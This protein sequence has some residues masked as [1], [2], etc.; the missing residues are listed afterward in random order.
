MPVFLVE[1]LTTSK[2][3]CGSSSLRIAAQMTQAMSST[4][5]D[6]NRGKRTEID[7]LNGFI[8]RRGLEL[9]VATPVNHTLCTLVR[10][11]EGR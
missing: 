5:Q 3:N 4:A 7:S 10:L 6:L 2:V 9:G 8:A 11:A 1:L